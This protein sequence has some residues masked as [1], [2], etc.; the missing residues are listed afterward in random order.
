MKTPDALRR[1]RCTSRPLLALLIAVPFLAVSIAFISGASTPPPV[2]AVRIKAAPESQDT[3]E[4][5]L[6]RHPLPEGLP[7]LGADREPSSGEPVRIAAVLH[8]TRTASLR[9]NAAAGRTSSPERRTAHELVLERRFLAPRVPL[10]DT[11]RSVPLEE[12]LR[13]RPVPLASIAPPY[14]ALAVEGLYVE[15]PAYPLTEQTELHLRLPDTQEPSGGDHAAVAEARERLLAWFEEAAAGHRPPQQPELTRIGG[16]GDMM[17]GRGLGSLLI[18]RGAEG[19]ETVFGDVL[20]L[21]SAQDLLLG[22]LEGTV[23]RGGTPTPKSYNFRFPPEILPELKSA[24]FDYLSLTNN[25]CWDYGRQGFTDTLEHFERYGIPTS[26]AGRTPEEAREAHVFDQAGNPVKVLSVGAYPPEKNGF[27]GK[28]QAAVSDDQPGI[29][30]SGKGA[31]EAVRDFTGDGSIDVV[32]VHGGEEWH[33]SP[34]AEQRRFYR[35][36][37]RAG[38]DLVLGSHPHVLQGLEGYEG[39]IIAYSLGNFLF[40]GMYVVPKA[41]DSM[42]LSV[43]FLGDRPLYVEPYP[44]RIDNRTLSS[45]RSEVILRRFARLTGNL[46]SAPYSEGQRTAGDHSHGQ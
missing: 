25:H 5:F 35:S 36:L 12:A 20:P 11:R 9:P 21:M 29:L 19:R 37:V 30:F 18:G 34:S 7:V 38:A 39:G 4:A 1:L 24:G 6:E 23:T 26:G 15:D 33:E 8:F 41:E 10:W 28:T 32:M 42:L 22:N 31:L 45:D 40:P 2:V 27:D 44:V 43:L 14:K 16:V 17:V 46:H 13:M 3:A